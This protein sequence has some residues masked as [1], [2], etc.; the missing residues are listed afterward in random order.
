MF[1]DYI[2]NNVASWFDW[3]QKNGLDVE[4]TEDLILVTGRSLVTSWAA[5]AFLGSGVAAEVSLIERPHQTGISLEF[6]NIRGNVARHCGR[7]DPVRP[8]CYI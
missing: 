7:F 8:L 4:R 6:S 3:S 1:E 2:R 5:V